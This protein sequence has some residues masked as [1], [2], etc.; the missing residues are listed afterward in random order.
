MER[1]LRAGKV[2]AVL[3][4]THSPKTVIWPYLLIPVEIGNEKRYDLVWRDRGNPRNGHGNSRRNVGF[5][6]SRI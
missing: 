3:P 2:S 1:C 4:K 5:T 6:L